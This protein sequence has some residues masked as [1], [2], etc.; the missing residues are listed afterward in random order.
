M[1]SFGAYFMLIFRR[2]KVWLCLGL[3]LRVLH[4]TFFDISIN[5]MVLHL[6]MGLNPTWY[7]VVFWRMLFP[8]LKKPFQWDRDCSF[9]NDCS[10]YLLVHFL[11]SK[12][13]EVTKPPWDWM[14]LYLSSKVI[15]SNMHLFYRR[16]KQRILHVSLSSF[17]QLRRYQ[18]NYSYYAIKWYVK[19]HTFCYTYLHLLV[20]LK[21]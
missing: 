12:C 8:K 2:F 11:Y 3:S 17:S 13:K 16:S 15:S 7:V 4:V 21:L 9:Q 6:F 1:Q 14:M 10:Q 19:V 18:E 20:L 5:E